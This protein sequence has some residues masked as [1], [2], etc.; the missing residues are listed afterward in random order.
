V[1][2]PTPVPPEIGPAWVEAVF[3]AIVERPERAMI[4]LDYDGTLAPIVDRPEEA[5]PAPGAIDA[6]RRLSARVG[7]LAFVTGRPVTDLL[8]LSG[9]D[10]AWSSGHAPESLVLRG[11]YGLERWDPATGIVVNP[12]VTAGVGDA[13]ALLPRLLELCPPGVRIEDKRLSLAVHTRETA[14]PWTS[15]KAVLPAL[16]E[17]AEETGLELALGRF[18]VELRPRGVDKGATLRE[19]VRE[20]KPDSL[21]FIGDDVGDEPAFEVV[22]QV[23]AE[24]TPAAAVLSDS[25]EAAPRMRARAHV[26]VPGPE[27]VVRLLTD[28]AD[29]IG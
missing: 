3:A 15:L 21:L 25:D 10:S 11:H 12:P 28:L 4:A 29:R 2:E 18:V 9:L 19:L 27:G 17:L 6:V 1:I 8:L 7:T 24:G 14:D 20:R 26:I 13:R 22:D 5:V 23:R 16:A